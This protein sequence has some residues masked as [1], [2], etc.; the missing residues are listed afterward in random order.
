VERRRKVLEDVRGQE[1]KIDEPPDEGVSTS[2][3]PV[4]DDRSREGGLQGRRRSQTE[5]YG[6]RGGGGVVSNGEKGEN[7]THWLK[8]WQG[9]RLPFQ[10]FASVHDRCSVVAEEASKRIE[11]ATREGERRSETELKTYDVVYQCGLVL[12]VG[13]KTIKLVSMA[14]TSEE[15][16]HFGSIDEENGK[17]R[18]D[19]GAAGPSSW[20][21]ERGSEGAWTSFELFCWRESE[22]SGNKL[23]KEDPPAVSTRPLP[24]LRLTSFQ[25]H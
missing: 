16:S 18:R 23:L 7:A 13:S 17:W 11:L 1:G 10:R 4:D 3:R 5:L 15:D 8:S 9:T 21:A 2:E 24:F 22:R 14:R 12:Y 19:R 25:T 20:A 6:S